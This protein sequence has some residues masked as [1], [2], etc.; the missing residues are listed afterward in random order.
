[1]HSLLDFYTD[2]VYPRM[3]DFTQ[4]ILRYQGCLFTE[5]TRAWGT[6]DPDIY[7]WDREGKSPEKFDN[8][9]HQNHYMNGHIDHCQVI[10]IRNPIIVRAVESRETETL[11]VR[12]CGPD[13]YFLRI[14][15]ESQIGSLYPRFDAS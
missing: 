1:M 3:K 4:K 13:Q 2:I 5:S 11:V 14:V 7:G 9:S 12:Q 8:E 6:L 15:G 10:P